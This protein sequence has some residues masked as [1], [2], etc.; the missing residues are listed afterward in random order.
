MPETYVLDSYAVL[1][2]LQ[3]EQAGKRI[4]D[5]LRQA[6]AREV[7]L[8]MTWI[9]VGEI[10]YIVERRRGKG[11]AYRALA[12]LEESPIDIVPVD[13]TLALRAASVKATYPMAYADAFVVALA[14][15]E[16]AKVV[17]GD[18]EFHKVS[19]MVDIEWLP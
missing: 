19:G 3:G 8:L 9:N 13:K 7:R 12:L 16:N 11:E 5:L 18:P 14:M 6:Q 1:T 10:L 4:L 17:T 15:E 2:L